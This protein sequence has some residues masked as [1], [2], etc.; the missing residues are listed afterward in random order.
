MAHFARRGALTRA[1]LGLLEPRDRR[2]APTTYACL[3]RP[4]APR[5]HAPRAVTTRERDRGVAPETHLFRSALPTMLNDLSRFKEERAARW[6]TRL[7]RVWRAMDHPDGKLGLSFTFMGERVTLLGTLSPK[8][9]TCAL[10]LA[11]SSAFLMGTSIGLGA[12]CFVFDVERD[13][14]V[15]VL[16]AALVGMLLMYVCVLAAIVHLVFYR[17]A[18]AMT[19][20][21]T[22]LEAPAR[23]KRAPN[24]DDKR[25]RAAAA[26]S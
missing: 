26:S 24:A 21:S 11:S 2:V 8:K 3:P 18:R 20:P 14:R 10:L 12:F 6:A 1:H 4:A 19:K 22:K 13:V 23:G 25:P 9:A 16:H 5:A 17:D 15:R 7:R